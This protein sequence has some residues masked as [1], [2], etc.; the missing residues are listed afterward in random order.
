MAR[1]QL[2]PWRDTVRLSEVDRGPI[3]RRLSPDASQL[4]AIARTIGVDALRRLDAEVTVSPWLD[5]AE[6][7]FSEG[8]TDLHTASYVDILAGGGFGIDDARPSI[9][10]VHYIRSAA[11]SGPKN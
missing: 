11:P 7:E 10:L 6:V 9:S 8:F 1:P 5:G 2:N 3:E 4:P